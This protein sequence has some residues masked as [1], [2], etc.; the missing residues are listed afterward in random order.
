MPRRLGYGRAFE[1]LVLGAAF[2]AERMREAGLVNAIV[3]ADDL[4]VT[5]LKAAAALAAKPPAALAAAR[6]LMRGDIR[7]VSRR[8]EDEVAIFTKALR[9]PEA[10]EAFQAFV[11]KRPPDFSKLAGGT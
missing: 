7:D 10:R 8:I 2:S 9:S 6:R 1:M 3:E 11:E 5:L 4:E